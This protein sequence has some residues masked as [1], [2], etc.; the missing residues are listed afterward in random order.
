MRRA[1]FIDRDGVIN[2]ELDYVHR[3]ED[4]HI[5]PG[6]VDGLRLLAESGFA[7]VV[8]TNQAG[9]AK[10]YYTEQDFQHLT[11]HMRTAFKAQGVELAAVYHCAHHPDGVVPGLSG[12]CDCRKP[13]P[14]MLFQAAR[15]L[16]LDLARSVMVGDKPSDTQAGRAAGVAWTVLVE[17]GHALPADATAHA[18]H[19]CAD[20]L[21]AARWLCEPAIL[22][23]IA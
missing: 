15:D 9:I 14:G 10:G 17:S 16:G 12:P 22:A 6:V 4:F 23:R 13:Q 11:A 2:E 18:D 21:A 7:L 20:L 8:V 3:V 19:R 1:A 5:L